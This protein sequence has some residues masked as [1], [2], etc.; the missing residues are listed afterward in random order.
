MRRTVRT[1]PGPE[2]NNLRRN[3][4]GRNSL[5]RNSL[6]RNSLGRNSLGRYS[7]GRYN[8]G[9]WGLLWLL[10]LLLPG[11]SDRDG[12]PA[13]APP[14][15]VP[16]LIPAPA[17]VLLLD[18]G[19]LAN[20]Q[21]C[22]SSAASSAVSSG[23]RGAADGDLF[24]AKVLPRYAQR[25]RVEYVANY[26]VV[27]VS[28]PWQGQSG[29]G[30][31]ATPSTA[32]WQYLL[33]QCGTPRPPGYPDA[34]VIEVPVKTVITTSSTELPHLDALGLVDRLVGHDEFDY[35]NSPAVRERIAAGHLIEVGSG[36]GLDLER[37][38]AASPGLLLADSLGT[39]EFS[40]LL[41]KLHELGIPVVL[42]PSFFETTPL[43]RAEW[44]LFTALFFNREDRAERLI[45]EVSARYQALAARGR[46]AEA[47]P[48]VLTGGPQGDVWY[49][50]G[51]QS[52]AALLLA[53]AGADYLWADD[54]ATGSLPLAVESVFARA[55]AADFWVHP[56]SWRS[57]DEILSVDR[58]FAELASV[59]T[60]RVFSND[61]RRNPAGGNDY[62]ETGTARPDL[63]LADLLHIFHPEL[64]PDH[65]LVFHRRL[66]SPQRQS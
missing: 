13:S 34:T 62:W 61:A 14:I 23:A 26:K 41:S 17:P 1:R 59:Q 48:T 35:V 38:I 4:L 49:V 55:L 19:P 44:L 25:F 36:A 32:S 24:P 12:Q 9:C 50:P 56:S 15:P 27:T 40:P 64:L 37:V 60:G 53:D 46:S 54:P 51:G 31:G 47:R 65:Q 43:G 21:D 3:S 66:G 45:A 29:T 20:P 58:R 16:P 6:G 8:L 63:V 11:C 52:Y 30:Q 10:W 42:A 2:R 39:P 57:L 28:T 18:D 5:G 7:L 33:V 22:V